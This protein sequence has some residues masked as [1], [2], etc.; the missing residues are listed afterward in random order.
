Y[1]ALDRSGDTR[2]AELLARLTN[3]LDDRRS[4]LIADLNW[5]IQNGL[6]YFAKVTRPEIAYARATDVLLFA[7]ALVADNRAGGREVA[8]TERARALVAAAY[9]PELPASVDPRVPVST[10]AAAVANLD[11]GT[12][13]VMCVLRP[14]RDLTL[15]ATDLA[16][17]LQTLAG[18][19]PISPV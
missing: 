13:Y 6:T 14:S 16:Q 7:P 9:G 12:R 10:L 11:A 2:P 18:G 1:P 5:Q 15:D 3:G 4:I 8:A 19:R 17:A